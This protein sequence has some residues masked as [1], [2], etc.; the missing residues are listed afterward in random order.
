MKIN[1]G[2]GYP[3]GQYTGSEWVNIDITPKDN[4]V[5]QMSVL[6]MP[7]DFSDKFEV[8]H[9]IHMLEHMNRNLRQQVINEIHRITAPGG[10]AYI[11]VPDFESIVG[12]LHDAYQK[13]DKGRVHLWKTSVYGKQRYEGDAHHWG[14]DPEHLIELAGI[15]GF[16][17]GAIWSN[18]NPE[19]M[20]SSHYQQEPVLLLEAKK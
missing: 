20:V 16:K 6:D 5:L 3:K 9:C 8:V 19:K 17:G 18:G 7:K 10:V 14:F 4:A 2:S 12:L 11:E 1:I 13:K 15:A